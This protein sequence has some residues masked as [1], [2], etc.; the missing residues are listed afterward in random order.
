MKSILELQAQVLEEIAIE[1]GKSALQNYEDWVEVFYETC[2]DEQGVG[3]DRTI[4]RN[5]N[6][7]Q[8]IFPAHAV[9]ECSTKLSQL[10]PRLPGEM[11]S[12]LTIRVKRSGE[13][14]VEYGY[15]EDP[16]EK[17]YEDWEHHRPF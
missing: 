8:D 11:W 15:E 16:F 1:L 12:R 14:D 6:E 17:F 7:R 13:V 4:V 5:G 9:S 3:A 10:R 2:L